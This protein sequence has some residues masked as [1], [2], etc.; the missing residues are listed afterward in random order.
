MLDE[1]RVID[2]SKMIEAKIISEYTK[3]L[4]GGFIPKSNEL[5]DK[6]RYRMDADC[7]DLIYG[8]AILKSVN[9][10]TIHDALCFGKYVHIH[11][12]KRYFECQ[13][14]LFVDW[15]SY[16]QVLRIAQT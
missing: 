1:D 3:M 9:T 6:V 14:M 13:N 16:Q 5:L 4:E 7:M 11:E 2:Q 12:G 10:D 8:P 15:F